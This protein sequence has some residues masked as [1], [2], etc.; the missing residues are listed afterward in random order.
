MKRSNTILL[1][2]VAGFLAILLAFTIY[3]GISMKRLIEEQGYLV[4]SR[5]IQRQLVESLHR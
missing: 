4:Y 1:I 3:M 5:P 2:A